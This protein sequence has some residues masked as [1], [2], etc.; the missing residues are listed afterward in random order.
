MK[1][2]FSTLA[3]PDW[4]LPQIITAASASGYNG[5]E[6]RFINNEDSLWKMPEFRGEQLAVSKRALS[7][8][9]LEIS[10]VDTSC[11]FHFPD[12]NERARW[13]DEGVRMAELAAALSA[14]GIRVF[15]DQIQPGAD[16]ESTRKWIA[17]S[18]RILA[19]K[20]YSLGVGVWLET[21]GD[22]ASAPETTAILDE[23]GSANTGTIW[24]P[25]NCY[26][27]HNEA[28]RVGAAGL[29]DR[30][31]QVHLKDMRRTGGEWKL[32]LTGEGDFPLAEVRSALCEIGFN[33]F[34]SF[35]WEK[36]WHP[37]IPDASVALPHFARWF[38]E[39]WR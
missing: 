38:R 6:L 7:D 4:N 3:C 31:R 27:E 2:S 1:L 33:G 15:G 5:I 8:L 25:A 9:G 22:F 26:L 14:P 16:R 11:R 20:T 28:P 34:V 23:V 10:C 30:I 29:R 21:H 24:D 12:A 13:I 19:E 32:V 17:D 36:K 35:E 37:E 18:I 39:N